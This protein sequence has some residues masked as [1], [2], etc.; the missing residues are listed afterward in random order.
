MFLR[1]DTLILDRSRI[2]SRAKRCFLVAGFFACL[3]DPACVLGAEPLPLSSA[4][5]KDSSFRKSFNGSYR[6]EARIEPSVST[7]ERTLL[8]EIQGLMGSGQRKTALSKVKGSSLTSTSAALKF[9]LGNLEFEEGNLE[10]AVKA[11]EGAITL[12]PSFRRA[13]RNLAMVLVRDGSLDEALEHL[14]EAIRLGDADGATFGLLGYCRL[15]RE[16]WGSALQAYQMAQ[17][18]QPGTADW[19]AGTAQCLQH[20]EAHAEAIAILDEVIDQR[21]DEPSYAILQASILIELSRPEDAVKTLELSRRL[22]RLDAGGLLL[23][24][25]LHLRAERI[26]DAKGAID[27][28]FS[29]KDKQGT[30][31]ILSVIASAM[32]VKEWAIASQLIEGAKPGV[33]DGARRLRVAS[34]RLKIESDEAPEEGANDLKKLLKGDPTDGQV[35]MALARYEAERG[36]GGEAE[37][38]F[39]RATAVSGF[40]ADAWVELARLMVDQKRYSRGLNAVNKAL[41]IRPGGD[42][43]DYRF[44]LAKLVSAAQ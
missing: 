35:L 11:Y 16:E 19:K 21:P 25:D 37:L 34:A 26:D 3:S 36:N 7:A 13:H 43:E 42:L 22:D 44:A 29:R 1:Q 9:N 8:V 40:A 6:I 31:R 14:V 33:G 5:W 20:L 4:Y 30:D 38:Y 28:A 18:T 32:R 24:A 15:Q 27:E 2:S 23:L 12:Y 17:L 10:A 39:E 41:A